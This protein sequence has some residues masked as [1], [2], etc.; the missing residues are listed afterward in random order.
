MRSKVVE[1]AKRTEIDFGS[2]LNYQ[3]GQVRLYTE[4]TDD[5]LRERLESNDKVSPIIKRIEFVKESARA[6]RR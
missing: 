5:I 6:G 1:E 2:G 3:T 4:K